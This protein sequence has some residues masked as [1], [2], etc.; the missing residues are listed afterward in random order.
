M[1]ED[2]FLEALTATLAL[3]F[4][5]RGA[6]T[7]SG[8]SVA[9]LEREKLVGIT[10][11]AVT[12][13]HEVNSP[14]TAILGNVQLLLRDQDKLDERLVAKLKTIEASAERIQ[15]VTR[16]LMRVRK[17]KSKQYS[18]GITMLDLSEEDQEGTED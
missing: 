4:A 8:S 2:S 17:P 6:T 16:L 11:T 7:S 5:A 15:Q 1:S 9:A 12:V 18:E 10:E 13:N 14:L 3:N